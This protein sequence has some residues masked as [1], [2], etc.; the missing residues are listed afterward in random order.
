[1]SAAGGLT[2][3][4]DAA[5]ALGS[6]AVLRDGRVVAEETVAMRSASE[7][8]LLPAVVRAVAAAGAEPAA[9]ERVVCGAGPG[10]FTG[11]RIAAAAA[12]GIAQPL[13]LPLYAVAS[14]ALVAA[15]AEPPLPPGAYLAVIDALRGER[16]AAA[17]RVD[18]HGGVTADGPGARLPEADVAAWAAA[19]RR[20]RIGPK[21]AEARWPHVRG[22][23]RLGAAPYAGGAVSLA[24]W[25]PDYGRHAE[26]QVQW[27]AAQG[28][29][30]RLP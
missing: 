1:M 24:D 25:E 20:T 27:E 18:D 11:L 26:A 10:S 6:V 21:E 23:A 19:E 28:R 12:K 8:R 17:L 29:P 9:L 3:A 22:L 2:L 30:L 15:G 16:F 13:G 14:L 4:L 5:S 7:E